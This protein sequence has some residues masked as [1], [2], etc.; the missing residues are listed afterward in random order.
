[1]RFFFWIFSSTRFFFVFFFFP[2]TSH[3][4]TRSLSHTHSLAHSHTLTSRGSF[5]F[6]SY[7]GPGVLRGG[8]VFCL[9]ADARVFTPEEAPFEGV[10]VSTVMNHFGAARGAGFM[11]ACELCGQGGDGPPLGVPDAPV[12]R[13]QPRGA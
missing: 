3:T 9:P 8:D 12:V 11:V 7:S 10:P 13:D 2:P 6:F 4:H 1:L 5:A